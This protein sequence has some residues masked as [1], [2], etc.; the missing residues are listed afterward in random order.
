MNKVQNPKQNHFGHL[1]LVL[2]IHLTFGIGDLEICQEVERGT[3][4]KE[5]GA[6]ARREEGRTVWG[7]F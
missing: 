5:N 6:E 3:R 2:G 1:E 4:D 7:D